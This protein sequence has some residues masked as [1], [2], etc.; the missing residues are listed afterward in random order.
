MRHGHADF[1]GAVRL[2]VMPENTNNEENTNDKGKKCYFFFSLAES[3]FLPIFAA[4]FRHRE[5]AKYNQ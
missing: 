1:L 3:D 2:S 5:D 4:S